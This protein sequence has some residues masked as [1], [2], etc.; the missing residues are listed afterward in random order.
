M[1]KLADFLRIV[2]ELLTRAGA[3]GVL[4]RR[5]EDDALD[6]RELTLDGHRAI[7]FGSCSY[8]GLEM[9]ERLK[10]AAIDAVQRFGT[11]FSSSR[12]YVELPLYQELED[13]LTRICGRP[14]L[15][16]PTTT[17][18]HA[19]ALPVLVDADD[20]VVVDQ[21]AHHSLHS[22][23]DHVR[24]QGTSVGLLRHQD[25]EQ[26]EALVGR[27]SR[28]HKRVW[29]LA[30]GVYSMFGELLPIDALAAMLD[31]HGCL[32]LYLDDAHGMSWFGRRGE[33]WVLS[34]LA[35]HERVVVTTS[36]AKGFG[37]GGGVIALP[38]EETRRRLKTV[39]GSFV[40]GGPLQPATLGAAIASAHIHLSGDLALRQALLMQRLQRFTELCQAYGLPLLARDNVPI[41]FIAA[42]PPAAITNL[43][44]RLLSEG[45]YTNGAIYPAVPMT[46]AGLRVTLTCHHSEA[47][48]EALV[49]AVARHLPEALDA[50]GSSVPEAFETFGLQPQK[51]DAP[52]SQARAEGLT[53]QHHR[54]VAELDG[55]EWN[56]LLGDEGTFSVEGLALLELAFRDQPLLEHCWQFHYFVVRDRS[57]T[58]ILLTFFTEAL[59]KDDMLA[60][61]G[62]SLAIEQQRLDSPYYLTSRVLAMGS[63]LTEGRHLYLDLSGNW[64]EALELMF[65]ELEVLRRTQGIATV[66]V[67]DVDP[68]NKALDEVL[69]NR[70]FARVSGPNSHV[71]TMPRPDE[72]A[73]LA[74]LSKDHRH[75]LRRKVLAFDG[76]YDV[77]ILGPGGRVASDREV[78][79]LYD[80]YR[81]VAARSLALN[82]FVLPRS[83]FAALVAREPWEVLLLRL[84][85]EVGGSPTGTVAAFTACHKGRT[86]Y[87]PHICGMDDRWVSSHGAYRQLNWQALRRAWALGYQRVRFGYGADVEKRRMGC[88]AVPQATYICTDDTYQLELLQAHF[89]SGQPQLALAQ[90]AVAASKV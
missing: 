7:N 1:K 62:V 66:M 64:R 60:P 73:H 48:L 5:V 67:R 86:T 79:Q 46:R 89:R 55:E 63:P 2:D 58:P 16:A 71:L 75:A 45:F 80:M 21:H 43:V 59:W 20:A 22:A 52:R 36:L 87:V 37:A 10:L 6:G 28:K 15:L 41:R 38:D 4:Y 82:T 35:R 90:E 77:E 74:S 69:L 27:L 72:A 50:A 29:Y 34:K 61:S 39:G 30:D 33:G 8:L 47:D 53:L 54:S 70:G 81:S 25:L 23:L 40:F 56:T 12:A 49:A 76:W 19:S 84:R 14:A 9:D 26:L 17:L 13:L 57:G 44:P 18:V 78:D 24:V 83:F 68:S 85:P 11:Q 65:R 32:H 88:A 3:A 31:R 42:G 51:S